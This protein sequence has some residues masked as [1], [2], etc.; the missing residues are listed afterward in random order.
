M[1]SSYNQ[2][3]LGQ[4]NA[5]IN[6]QY[7]GNKRVTITKYPTCNNLLGSKQKKSV[8]SFSNNNFH[9]DETPITLEEINYITRTAKNSINP[10][11]LNLFATSNYID[12]NGTF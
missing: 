9:M 4:T 11:L 3:K 2:Y 8:F 12:L 5:D 10:S 7:S 6:Q 1:R